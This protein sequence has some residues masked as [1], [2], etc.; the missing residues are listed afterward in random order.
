VAW[1]DSLK[2]VSCLNPSKS[3]K[4]YVRVIRQSLAGRNNISHLVKDTCGD[5][6][7][8]RLSVLYLNASQSDMET[9]AR[10]KTAH[11][12]NID[13]STTRRTKMEVKEEC[14]TKA[15]AVAT[16]A[17]A[18]QQGI[19][20]IAEFEHADMVNV[21]I[22]DATPRPLFTPKAR[23]STRHQ[24]DSTLAMT[25]DLET[26]DVEILENSESESPFSKN[27]VT[28]N[29]LSGESDGEAS[30]ESPPA[31]KKPRCTVKTVQTV[32]ATAP[33]AK[34]TG[35]RK[36]PEAET[37]PAFNEEAPKKPK[38]KLKPKPKMT[39][40]DEINLAAKK[41]QENKD[42]GHKEHDKVRPTKVGAASKAPSQLQAAGEDEESA[43]KAP[44]QSQTWGKKL[45]REGA[46]AN[47]GLLNQSTKCSHEIT[48]DN[49][50]Y[51]FCIFLSCFHF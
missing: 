23:P 36:V 21:D 14:T 11:P 16:C 24:K 33:M 7:Q 48:A 42:E 15:Q 44:L 40:R 22:V 26:S 46:I 27:S 9:R 3:P 31:K 30:F 41:I 12:G 4:S 32:K 39:V 5:T 10:N 1:L 35:K 19:N 20:H 18:K 45:K 28:H 8:L 43:L 37:E 47:I 6:P 2:S 50:R 38:L 25:T 17:K 49:N 29:S 34:K 13:K 51:Y